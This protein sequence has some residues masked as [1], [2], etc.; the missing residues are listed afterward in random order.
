MSKAAGDVSK[1]VATEPARA[2]TFGSVCSFNNL[3][4]HSV[5]SRVCWG[6]VL[7]LTNLNPVTVF[8]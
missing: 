4:K 1:G 7:R 3:T 5:K 2:L 6:K 8:A